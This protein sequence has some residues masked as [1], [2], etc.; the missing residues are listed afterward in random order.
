ME[1]K[2]DCDNITTEVKNEV[3]GMVLNNLCISR[4][5]KQTEFS[6]LNSRKLLIQKK[7]LVRNS[8]DLCSI[9]IKKTKFTTVQWASCLLSIRNILSKPKHS[10]PS[11]STTNFDHQICELFSGFRKNYLY[12]TFSI[13]S[14]QL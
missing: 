13:H 7:K 1:R 2:W 6:G 12:G 14:K 3:N 10:G 11:N 8:H 5:G 9:A 4:W